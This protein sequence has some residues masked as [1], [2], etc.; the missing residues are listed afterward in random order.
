MKWNIRTARNL[1]LV[2]SVAVAAFAAGGGGAEAQ[3][4]TTFNLLP[5]TNF[6]FNTDT[7]GWTSVAGTLSHDSRD[8]DGMA[9]S[10]SASLVATGTTAPNPRSAVA[11]QCVPIAGFAGSFTGNAVVVLSVYIPSAQS[12]SGQASA[13]L[14]AYPTADCSGGAVLP[15]AP[16]T[17]DDRG[18]AQLGFGN[19]PNVASNS[20]DQVGKWLTLS[21]WRKFNNGT[22]A[23]KAIL[24]QLIVG[25]DSS[26]APPAGS[27][28]QVLFDRVLLY[29]DFAA[30]TTPTATAT[31]TPTATATATQS[32][33][34]TATPTGT[35][36]ATSTATSTPTAQPASATP[37]PVAPG[38][39]NTG[40]GSAG[41][42]SGA[43]TLTV[44]L[45]IAGAISAV[46][47]FL[48]LAARRRR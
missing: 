26:N 5:T 23:A 18:P 47:G 9:G 21:T 31:S 4:T 12:Q 24:V 14:T 10:G 42:P 7:A 19:P 36:V 44:A 40:S 35:A 32:P 33:T 30:E 13:A 46:G 29:G 45:A 17:P 3:S 16:V 8:R 39:P 2:A 41:S 22:V 43:N 15:V 28:F 25:T 34:A 1:V 11:T 6:M 20:A 37:T 27:Q 38:P 48:T